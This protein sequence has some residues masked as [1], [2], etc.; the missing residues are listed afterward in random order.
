MVDE[1]MRVDNRPPDRG[2]PAID[3]APVVDVLVI[4]SG[5]EAGLT[6]QLGDFSIAA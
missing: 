5:A 6:A 1:E 2:S 3:E 4:G